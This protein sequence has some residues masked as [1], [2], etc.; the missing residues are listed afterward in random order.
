[1]AGRPEDSAVVW[2][3]ANKNDKAKTAG[4]VARFVPAR[5]PPRYISRV[6]ASDGSRC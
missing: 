5:R 1:M 4:I 3:P 6:P 2:Q